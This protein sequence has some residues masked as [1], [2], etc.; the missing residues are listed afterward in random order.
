MLQSLLTLPEFLALPESK[1]ALEYIDGRIVQKAMPKTRHARL[2]S[3]LIEKINRI[4][5]T[6]KIAYAFPEL[7][8]TFA[9][10]SIVPDIAVLLWQNIPFDTNGEPLDNILIPP[11][12]TIEIL[13]PEQSS[14]R[15]TGNI[16]Y[17]LKHGCKLGW[18]LDAEDRSI[19]IFLP[20]RPPELRQ[21]LDRLEILPDIDLELTV[22][23][24]FS[25]LKMQ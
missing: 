19:L 8:C 1:P 12:W 14:N 13:S 10:R 20:D 22:E 5:E 23:A 6:E 4:T 21:G 18:L 24:V 2:Q 7:R 15:V 11:D 16:L 25:W 17:C 3:K 9:G